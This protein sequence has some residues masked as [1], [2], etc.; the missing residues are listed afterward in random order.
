[1]KKII[2]LVLAATLTIACNEKNKKE[3]RYIQ[4][5]SGVLNNLSVVIDNDLWK[6]KV[7][8]A[9]RDVVTTNVPGLPQNEPM[10][11]VNQIPPQVFKDFA[12]KNR[13]VL[14]VN[15]GKD[16]GLKIANNV[17]AKPQ[18]VVF[19]TGQ[20]NDQ[21]IEILKANKDKIISAF[22]AQEV[23]WRQ[24]QIK[25]SVLNTDE[26]EEKLG[27]TITFPSI[28]RFAKKDDNFFWIRKNLSTGTNNVMLYTIPYD[29]INKE[30]DIIEQVIKH[31][32][33]LGKKYIPGPLDGSYMKTEEAYSPFLFN[34]TIDNKPTYEVRSTWDIEGTF[35]AGPFV[36][37]MIEDKPNNRYIVA[38]GFTFAP[39]VN[40]RDFV[41]ELEAIIKSL[42][43]K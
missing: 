12:T 43:V 3:Q 6:G 7:G 16:A 11:D 24:D 10:F 27:V 36:N 37:Y 33:S 2:L 42:K 13:T 30:G 31:R 22:K 23:K 26:V 1:M 41:L 21:I 15:K 17:Y 20:N 4:D 9:V 35:N 14:R 18:K 8:D 28:Y 32:D 40:K 38:E 34:T 29:S 39:S 19:V 25:K 5:S